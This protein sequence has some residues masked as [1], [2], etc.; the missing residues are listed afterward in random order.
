M[1]A[2]VGSVVVVGSA[3]V[4]VVVTTR[5]F[6]R[7]GETIAGSGVALL[8]GGKGANQAVAARRAGAATRLVG[9]V[10]D[11]VFAQQLRAFLEGEDVRVDLLRT[12]DA[13]PSGM[14]VVTVAEDGQNAIVVVAGANATL[15][16]ADV[17][18]VPIGGGDVVVCQLEVPEPTV[19]AAV[20]A[21]RSAGATAILNPAPAIPVDRS[22]LAAADVVVL[23]EVELAGYTRAAVDVAEDGE[24]LAAARAL[25]AG[26]Q[27][28]V[29]TLG[30][31]GVLAVGGREVL[32]LKGEPATTVDTTGA[33]D[34][35]VGV[36][37]AGL[38]AGDQMAPSLR[39]A[40]VAASLTVGRRGAGPA[41][42]TAAEIAAA[43]R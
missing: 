23:N 13:T 22:L 41:M 14:A 33:G 34:C 37:A 18:S 1:M 42:P 7:A 29:V 17:E 25:G 19:A 12:T 26:D 3:N 5:R 6:P 36:L 8:P 21:A 30:A 40:N 27:W 32:R 38:A 4:D 28:V 31:R 43:G 20:A 2:L 10:G 9:R 24:V 35:F 39:R 15:G 11:D 16:R